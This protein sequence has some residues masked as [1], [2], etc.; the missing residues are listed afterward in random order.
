MSFFPPVRLSCVTLDLTPPSRYVSDHTRYSLGLEIYR[1]PSVTPRKSSPSPRWVSLSVVDNSSLVSTPNSDWLTLNGRVISVKIPEK[2]LFTLNYVETPTFTS[3]WLIR[4]LLLFRR[5]GTDRKTNKTWL[6][7][8]EGRPED[9]VFILG[10]LLSS[11][12][13]SWNWKDQIIV[14]LCD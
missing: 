4:K 3:T 11:V 12:G 7:S 9:W 5:V 1:Y 13:G 8:K 10:S 2:L 14:E 6:S